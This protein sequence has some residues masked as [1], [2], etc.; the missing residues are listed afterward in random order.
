[1]SLSTIPTPILENLL[2]ACQ[3]P[4]FVPTP[5][6]LDYLDLRHRWVTELSCQRG[7]VVFFEGERGDAAY[8][9]LSGRVAVI[10]GD[11]R[12]PV[13]LGS[14][15]PGEIIGE[16]ALLENKPRSASVVALEPL[17]L[18]CVSSTDFHRLLDSVPSLV[19]HVMSTL[20]AR[21]RQAD[22]MFSTAFQAEEQ[23][24]EELEFAGRVQTR[25]LPE[26]VP[27]VPGWNIAVSLRPARQTYGDFYDFVTLDNGTLGFVIADVT[28]K[29]T[30][31]ALYMALSRTLIRTYAMQ[32]P[33]DPALALEAAN[34]RALAD[35]TS[36]Q[37][38]TVF[39][40][41]LE[42]NTG[43][44]V[45]ANAGHNPAYVLRAGR[46]Q[47]LGKTGTPLG[48]LEGM[49]WQQRSISLEPGDALV[50]YTDGLCEAQNS[51]GEQFGT[52]RLV[53]AARSHTGCSAQEIHDALITAVD[54]FV[55]DESPF[56][57][58][59]VLVAVRC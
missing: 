3:P 21:L 11:W 58:M 52:P 43:T 51:S 35:T 48:I 14:R 57:D 49:T 30:G 46:T 33:A 56:D 45:Y 42:P 18:L 26:T 38:V 34:A 22:Q 29:G 12:N 47:E 37:F 20:S 55:G 13:I 50:L 17:R 54:D 40:G 19:A 10:K 27:Q 15:G 44:L 32:H 36:N 24:S 8:I 53:D 9:I 23:L 4:S 28:D 7:D 5:P 2:A 59:T 6:V 39:Y 1:M 31:A 41:V 16:M 25:F